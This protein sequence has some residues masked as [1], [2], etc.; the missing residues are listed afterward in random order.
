MF[1]CLGYIAISH[2]FWAAPSFHGSQV[3]LLAGLFDFHSN[4]V[5]EG[6]H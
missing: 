5:E 3:L 1:T 6:N 4:V 2:P